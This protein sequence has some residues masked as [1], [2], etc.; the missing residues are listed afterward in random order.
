[1][2]QAFLQFGERTRLPSG[3]GCPALAGFSLRLELMT[4]LPAKNKRKRGITD[5]DIYL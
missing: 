1:V 4:V 5:H 3:L 2:E